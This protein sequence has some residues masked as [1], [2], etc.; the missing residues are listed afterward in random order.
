V[1]RTCDDGQEAQPPGPSR[2]TRAVLIAAAVAAVAAAWVYRP[3]LGFVL[4]MALL[5]AIT[6]MFMK[7]PPLDQ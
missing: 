5:L 4:G 7:R 3:T 6:A 1:E 2:R